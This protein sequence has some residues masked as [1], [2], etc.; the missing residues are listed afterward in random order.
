MRCLACDR[1]FTR[2]VNLPFCSGHCRAAHFRECDADVTVDWL[3]GRLVQLAIRSNWTME[4]RADRRQQ[5]TFPATI[6]QAA[7]PRIRPGGRYA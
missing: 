5:P 7:M 3:R 1:E 4:E 6:A 2:T